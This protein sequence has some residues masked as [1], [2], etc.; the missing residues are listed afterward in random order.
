MFVVNFMT[1]RRKSEDRI[2]LSKASVSCADAVRARLAQLG[3]DERDVT[4]A[5]LA[6]Q[7]RSVA[8]SAGPA[9]GLIAAGSDEGHK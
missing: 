8:T 6:A 7:R 9:Q 2:T 1:T 3:V 4:A 5:V